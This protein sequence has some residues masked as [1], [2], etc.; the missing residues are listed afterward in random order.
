MNQ[1]P[2]AAFIGTFPVIC[3]LGVIVS[4][5]HLK[6]GF[7]FSA[8]GLLLVTAPMLLFL[9]RVFLTDVARTDRHLIPYTIV[10]G[11]GLLISL[12]GWIT[13]ASFGLL[14]LLSI[15]SVIGYGLYVWW[16]SIFP[17]RDNANLA[18]GASLA[19]FS[20]EDGDGNTVTSKSFLGAKNIFLFYRGNWCPLCMT[21]IKEIAAKYKELEA[22]G[23]QTNLI[24]P[25]PHKL[26]KSL[27]KKFDVGFNFLVDKDNKVAKAFNIFAKNGLP[28][29]LQVLGY[30]SDTVMPTIILTDEKGKIVYSDLTTNY[31][32]RPEPEEFLKYFSAS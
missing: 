11:I 7:T 26:T 8:L 1:F 25:Q 5:L 12:Y 17:N 13:E 24:S 6:D 30:D 15:L 27:A 3:L 14:Q 32:M 10:V 18:A 19:N 9:G 28:M 29:G 20:L 23:I 2:K 22:K 21:Q 16:Y 31:R 4:V